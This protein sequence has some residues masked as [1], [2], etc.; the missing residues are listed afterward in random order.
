MTPEGRV[1]AKLKKHLAE[2]DA[3]QFWPV[4][5]GYGQAMV[6]CL[7]WLP[8]Q[9]GKLAE[10]WAIETKRPGMRK[11]TLRQATV[12]REMRKAGVR[13]FIVTADDDGELIWHEIDA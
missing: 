3:Y 2:K 1:K 5:T 4:Q 7:A 13:T 12:M 8:Q 9:R 6:D 11:P 10:A